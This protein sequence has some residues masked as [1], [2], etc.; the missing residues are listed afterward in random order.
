MNE[1][2]FTTPAGFRSFI[3]KGKTLEDAERNFIKVPLYNVHDENQSRQGFELEDLPIRK[4]YE[5]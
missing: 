1:Y 2:I 5:R 4:L 3:V